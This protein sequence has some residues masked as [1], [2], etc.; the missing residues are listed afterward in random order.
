MRKSKTKAVK[1]TRILLQGGPFNQKYLQM[2]SDDTLVFRVRKEEYGYYKRIY[3]TAE[4][5]QI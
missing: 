4:W 2:S 1:H 3:K 5:I